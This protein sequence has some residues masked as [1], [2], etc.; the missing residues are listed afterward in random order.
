MRLVFVQ[1]SLLAQRRDENTCNT[2]KIDD[3]QDCGDNSG[4][5][6]K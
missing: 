5:G 3:V 2:S 6:Q 1:K 4:D